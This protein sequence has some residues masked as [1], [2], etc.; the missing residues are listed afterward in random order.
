MTL[1]IELIPEGEGTRLELNQGPMAEEMRENAT[2]GWSQAFYKLDALLAT[3]AH[4][5][6]MPTDEGDAT[7]SC[8]SPRSASRAKS[9][10]S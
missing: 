6:T 3:P 4:L 1:S 10:F 9:W 5:R 7:A 8:S 2:V